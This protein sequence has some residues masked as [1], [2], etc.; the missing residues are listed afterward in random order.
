MRDPIELLSKGL[1][2][3]LASIGSSELQSGRHIS[4]SILEKVDASLPNILPIEWEWVL[5]CRVRAVRSLSLCKPPQSSIV[6]LA[7]SLKEG[8]PIT[9]IGWV[10][11]GNMAP[12]P[13][14][15]N[16]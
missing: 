12:T 16:S 15:Q 9:D 11:A 13:W 14:A 2:S 7:G 3:E 4:G 6:R 8:L 1:R 10:V 5:G